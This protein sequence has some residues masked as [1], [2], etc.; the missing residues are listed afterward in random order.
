MQ[1][2]AVKLFQ[3]IAKLRYDVYCAKLGYLNEADYEDGQET[4]HYDDRS[5]HIAAKTLDGAGIGT[6]RL[7][8]GSR[9]AQFPFEQHCSVDPHFDLPPRQQSAEVS[10]LIVRN[11]HRRIRAKSTQV[12]WKDARRKAGTISSDERARKI[13]DVS[14][15]R[16]TEPITLELMRA[17]YR[18]SIRNDIRY[19][20]AAMEKGLDKLLGRLGFHFVPIGPEADYYGPVTSY[21][22]DLRKLEETLRQSNKPTLAWFQDESDPDWLQVSTITSI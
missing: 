22:A 6:V 1:G 19:W 8:L 21:V 7:V 2:K 10:R 11:N 4:D 15:R 12:I 18:Y 14:Q 5:I 20:Y 16:C 17:M 9:T 3:E 13:A